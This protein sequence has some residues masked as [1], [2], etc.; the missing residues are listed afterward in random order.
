MTSNIND[1]ISPITKANLL[2]A[3]STNMGLRDKILDINCPKIK[4]GLNFWSL[5]KRA[6]KSMHSTNANIGSFVIARARVKIATW[7]DINLTILLLI[8]LVDMG[9]VLGII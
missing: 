4:N 5:K 1:I 3:S 8:F 2:G 7:A 9:H 6:T